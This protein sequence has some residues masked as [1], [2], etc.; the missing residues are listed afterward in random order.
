MIVLIWRVAGIWL[1]TISLSS[2]VGTVVRPLFGLGDTRVSR[3][4]ATSLVRIILV[5]VQLRPAMLASAR[6]GRWEDLA[7]LNDDHL[8]EVLREVAHEMNVAG[9]HHVRVAA[10]GI[11]VM[12]AAN[13]PQVML[14]KWV[15]SDDTSAETSSGTSGDAILEVAWSPFAPPIRHAAVAVRLIDTGSGRILGRAVRLIVDSRFPPTLEQ[16]IA[17]VESGARGVG[18]VTRK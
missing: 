15:K 16:G 18:L 3:E 6:G 8:L 17:A 12:A 13:E 11:V 5:V 2:C 1:V 7:L 4:E 10:E 9:V 14:D